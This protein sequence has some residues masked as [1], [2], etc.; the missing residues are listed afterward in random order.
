VS[1]ILIYR[2]ANLT[3][4]LFSDDSYWQSATPEDPKD[5]RLLVKRVFITSDFG[6][7]KIPKWAGWVKVVVDAEDLPL[8]V[9]R[10]TLQNTRFIK[11][12]KQVILKHLIQLFN[13]VAEEDPEKFKEMQAVYNNVFKIGAVEDTKNQKKLVSLA[14]FTT[15]Q[16]ENTTLDE[17]SRVPSLRLANANVSY[18]T[19]TTRG[20]DK[21]RYVPR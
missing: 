18:S 17:V 11:Q 19:S 14:R 2:Q 8:N 15:N 21:A 12:I 20:R 7:N 10:E 9:S 6:D 13:R 4:P 3:L 16:R 5:I 1:S